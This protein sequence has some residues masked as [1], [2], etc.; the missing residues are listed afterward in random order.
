[1]IRLA[2]TPLERLYVTAGDLAGLDPGGVVMRLENKIRRLDHV[3][4]A[5]VEALARVRREMGTAESRIG[6]P[7]DQEERL[8]TLR[9]RQ[10]RDRGGADTGRVT[11]W[12]ARE[13]RWRTGGRPDDAPTPARER[14]AQSAGRARGMDCPPARSG[15]F[16][17]RFPRGWIVVG[18]AS[19]GRGRQ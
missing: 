9:R 17:W 12:P 14:G 6:L 2:D 10:A 5:T 16:R 3:R 13:P 19:A 4:E 7:F 1:M 8:A 15:G 18:R 11:G